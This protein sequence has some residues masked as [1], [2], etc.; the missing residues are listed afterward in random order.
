MLERRV[1]LQAITVPPTV[2]GPELL[3]T[4]GRQLQI[5]TFPIALN[6]RFPSLSPL[7]IDPIVLV[8]LVWLV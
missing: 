7:N 3:A 8:W 6:H 5:P 2:I 1:V 4:E